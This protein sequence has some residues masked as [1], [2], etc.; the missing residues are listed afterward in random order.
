[1]CIES[2]WYRKRYSTTSG[3]V[4]GGAIYAIHLDV[5]SMI[6]LYPKAFQVR[7][8]FRRP[9]LHICM[10]NSADWAL[11]I[12]ELLGMTAGAGEMAVRPR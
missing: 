2:N 1:M 8:R 12:R 11:F 3:F 9:R 5:S 6:K 10:T 4:T 7:K